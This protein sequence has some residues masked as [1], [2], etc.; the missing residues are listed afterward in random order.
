MNLPR[1]FQEFWTFQRWEDQWRLREIEQAGESDLLKEENFVEML[2]DET[3]RGIYGETAEKTGAAGPW[4][5]KGAE[6]K[7]TRIDRMLNFLVQTDKL[8][9]RQ[10]MLERARQVFLRVHLAEDS[11]DP[12]E[13]PISDLFPEPASSPSGADPRAAGKRR[14]GRVPQPLRAQGGIDPGPE[15]LRPDQG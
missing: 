14:D 6:E 11:T 1:G 13:A 3:L 5:E 10:Q 15:F 12:A 2:T 7:A 8:W 9:N 4:L